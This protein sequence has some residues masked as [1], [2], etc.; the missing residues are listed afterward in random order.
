MLML[1]LRIL[2]K[3]LVRSVRFCAVFQ[4]LEAWWQIKLSQAQAAAL[5]PFC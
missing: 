2:L 5:L 4:K 3:F 1:N